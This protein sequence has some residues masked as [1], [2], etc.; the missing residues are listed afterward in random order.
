MCIRDSFYPEE[1]KKQQENALLIPVDQVLPDCPNHS[2]NTTVSA[3]AGAMFSDEKILTFAHIYYYL[4]F[5]QYKNLLKHLVNLSTFG[6]G[7]I[8]YII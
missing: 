8:Y 2:Y 5:L 4:L 7:P 3:L 6:Q 1:L